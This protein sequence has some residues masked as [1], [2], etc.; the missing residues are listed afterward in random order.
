MEHKVVMEVPTFSIPALKGA[1]GEKV[2]DM[3]TTSGARICISS[4]RPGDPLTEVSISGTQHSVRVASLL[5][6]MAVL[7]GRA[8]D[9]LTLPAEYHPD[10]KAEAELNIS[11]FYK[12]TRARAFHTLYPDTAVI[13]DHNI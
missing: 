2:K 3:C 5:I 10:K 7:H 12:E 6:K 9:K 13:D 4:P 8:A 11:V 1:A